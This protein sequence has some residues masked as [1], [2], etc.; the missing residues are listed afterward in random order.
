MQLLQFQGP[1]M[2]PAQFVTLSTPSGIVFTFMFH[3]RRLIIFYIWRKP[4]S[5]H[6]IWVMAEVCLIQTQSKQSRV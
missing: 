5:V 1:G 6:M 4:W 3:L 2:Q